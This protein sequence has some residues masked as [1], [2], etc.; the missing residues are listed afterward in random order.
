MNIQKAKAERLQRVKANLGLH[1]EIVSQKT[2]TNQPI[3][4]YKKGYQYRQDCRV[5]TLMQAC[6]ETQATT[7]VAMARRE[8]MIE[9]S[10]H[11]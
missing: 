1:S 11:H 10:A 5:T 8:M 6:A 3:K 4:G 7:E 9:L 2:P